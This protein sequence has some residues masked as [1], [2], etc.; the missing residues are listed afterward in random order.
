MSQLGTQQRYLNRELALDQSS[1]TRL[2]ASVILMRP[3]KRLSALVVS[4][5]AIASPART[6]P[7]SI[8][9]VK[10]RA[11]SCSRGFRPRRL[12]TDGAAGL[13]CRPPY[14]ALVSSHAAM[15]AAA[16]P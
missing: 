9:W 11:T 13:G 1:I 16:S 6:R 5:C 3:T 7:V 2:P 8:L 14:V 10:R 4:C 12:L 15:L